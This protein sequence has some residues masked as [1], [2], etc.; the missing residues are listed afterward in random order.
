[1]FGIFGTSE[2]ESD[3]R[4]EITKKIE[5]IEKAFRVTRAVYDKHGLPDGDFHT[6]FEEF[7]NFR[8]MWGGAYGGSKLQ[9]KLIRSGLNKLHK[10]RLLI[11]SNLTQKYGYPDIS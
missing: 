8:H 9:L 6:A 1:M 5:E 11:A 4:S 10:Q 2:T 7:C 3:I